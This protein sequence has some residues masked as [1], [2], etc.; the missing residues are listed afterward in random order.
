MDAS[1]APPGALGTS[2]E[3][4]RA[5]KALPL[6]VEAE[7]LETR[8]GGTE[9]DLRKAARRADVLALRVVRHPDTDTR[10]G[11]VYHIYDQF[12]Q[13]VF[14]AVRLVPGYDA[15]KGRLFQWMQRLPDARRAYDAWLRTL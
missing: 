7:E 1:C 6:P 10:E 2:V 12:A 15:D 5:E 3:K 9:D 4:M 11:A 8:F 14:G 13:R